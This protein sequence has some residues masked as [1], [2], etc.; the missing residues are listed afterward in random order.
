M[1]AY[2][3]MIDLCALK[4]GK[5]SVKHPLEKDKSTKL[6][7]LRDS[8]SPKKEILGKCAIPRFPSRLKKR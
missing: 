2:L 5:Q 8:N 3:A 1:T 7:A 6:E 4:D